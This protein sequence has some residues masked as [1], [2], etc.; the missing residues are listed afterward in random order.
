MA[1]EFV[2]PTFVHD[3]IRRI[4]DARAEA[5][6]GFERMPAPGDPGEMDYWE[7]VLEANARQVLGALEHTTL[8]PGMA[9]RY[10]F[11]EM[12]GGDL[13]ARPFVARPGTDVDGFKRLLDWHPP[14]DAAG[15][16]SGRDAELL[17]RHFR[18]QRSPEGVFEYW[19]ALQEI[20][21]SSAW[22]HA[23]VIASAD[24]LGRLTSEPEWTVVQM[25]EHCAPAVAAGEESS[26]LAVLVYSPVRQQRIALEQITIGA[27]QS[28]RYGEPV[29]VATGPRGWIL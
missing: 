1:V 8:E 6:R 3:L 18:Y 12:R 29:V 15:V 20:W 28:I 19:F 16:V 21:A 26:H 11:Y 14:P 10:R 23:R 27:D 13:R 24:E 4:G 22:A 2:P 7:T 5:L 17:Y 9:V 25:A